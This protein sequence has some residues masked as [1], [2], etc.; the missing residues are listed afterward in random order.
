MSYGWDQMR[1]VVDRAVGEAVILRF[2]T[3]SPSF[4][5]DP[6]EILTA[7]QDVRR[8]LDRVEELYA[9]SMR[10]KAQAQ[11][12]R[13]VCQALADD[14][15]DT[16]ITGARTG[17]RTVAV[18]NTRDEFVSA[19]ERDAEANL[20]TVEHRRKARQADDA[21]TAI[22]ANVEVLRTIHRGLDS[23]RHDLLTVLRTL[24]FESTLDR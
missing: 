10:V 3:P 16:A 22:A 6:A 15:W 21:Y 5:A 8:R 20:A 11:R 24:A 14:A 12:D 17:R 2:D 1:E 13:A 19:K 4:D 7:L 23:V 18:I 9:N